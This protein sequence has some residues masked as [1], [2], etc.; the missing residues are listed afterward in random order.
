M[1]VSFDEILLAFEF[2]SASPNEH[3]AFLGIK[4]G[5]IY[6]RSDYPSWTS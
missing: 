2:V 3:Q 1:A 6:W 5:K 4:S